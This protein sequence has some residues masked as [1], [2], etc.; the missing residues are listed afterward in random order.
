VTYVIS[1]HTDT[2]NYGFG[3]AYFTSAGVDNPPLHALADGADGANGVYLY[4]AGAFPTES[5]NGANYWV[6]VVYSPQ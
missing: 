6:D 3:G 2:G 5:F 1:Y 4:G